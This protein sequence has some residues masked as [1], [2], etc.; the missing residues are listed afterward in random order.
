MKNPDSLL[1]LG[2]VVAERQ[3]A[4]LEGHVPDEATRQRLAH[5][6][7]VVPRPGNDWSV[8]TGPFAVWVKGT[9][10]EVSYDPEADD[11]LLELHEG[12]VIVSGCGFGKGRA[13]EAGE[14]VRASCASRTSSV[15]SLDAPLD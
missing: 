3:D 7:A 5:R 9:K 11:F 12:K 8:R 15:T 13:V 14:R 10:F 2:R 4:L 1:D 6:A